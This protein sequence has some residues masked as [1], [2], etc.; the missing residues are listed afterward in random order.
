MWHW[1]NEE[2]VNGKE[3]L[4]VAYNHGKAAIIWPPIYVTDLKKKFTQCLGAIR[5]TRYSMGNGRIHTN[6]HIS[7]FQILTENLGM[8]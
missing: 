2:C 5:S 4:N 3:I 8:W 7:V 1:A 6:I